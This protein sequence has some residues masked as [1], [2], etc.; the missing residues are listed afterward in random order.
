MSGYT[1]KLVRKE[2]RR[3]LGDRTSSIVGELRKQVVALD[4]SVT[5]LRG[6]V[7][8]ADTMIDDIVREMESRKQAQERSA[9]TLGAVI[10]GATASFQAFTR[11]GVVGRFKWLLLGR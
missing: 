7:K 6:A 8:S 3:V 5:G 1:A 11:R 9:A 10:S 4:E 2:A